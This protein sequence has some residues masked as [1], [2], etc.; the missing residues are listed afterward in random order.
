MADNEWL[1]VF[2]GALL[3]IVALAARG[4]QTSQSIFS[5][6]SLNSLI[7]TTPGLWILGIAGIVGV[8]AFFI[9]KEGR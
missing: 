1:L 5:E 9:P 3:L 6:F 2:G 4:P 8:V 7:S